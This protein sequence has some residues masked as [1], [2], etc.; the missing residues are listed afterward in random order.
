MPRAFELNLVFCHFL[1]RALGVQASSEAMQR[2]WITLIYLQI[3]RSTASAWV[4]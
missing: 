3:K 1:L 2:A 4:A